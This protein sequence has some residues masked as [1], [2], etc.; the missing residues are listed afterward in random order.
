MNGCPQPG[1]P[2]NPLFGQDGNYTTDPKDPDDP[3]KLLPRYQVSGDGTIAD[4]ITGLLWEVRTDD[5]KDWN[6]AGDLI[7]T[8]NV[9]SCSGEYCGWRLPTRKELLFIVDFGKVSPP[10]IDARFTSTASAGYWTSNDFASDPGDAWI[11]RFD[12]G[13]A[14]SAHK[15]EKHH[16]LA[17]RSA[18]PPAADCNNLVDSQDGTVTDRC[19]GLMWQQPIAE[20]R[21]IWRDALSYADG[22]ELAACTDW[23]VP[24][25]KELESIVALDRHDPAMDTGGFP[26]ARSHSIW[27]STTDAGNPGH[28]WRMSFG[29]GYPYSGDKLNVFSVRAVRTLAPL[30]VSALDP[31]AGPAGGGTVVTL[32]GT[33][34]GSRQGTGSVSLGSS[35]G[36]SSETQATVASWAECQIVCTVPAHD[37]GAVSVTV[38]NDDGASF[39]TKPETPAFTYT[40]DDAPE[41]PS[42][43]GT[44]RP[45]PPA[46]PVLEMA[47]SGRQITLS[48]APVDNATGYNLILAI[49]P[50]PRRVFPV[51]L[52]N[53]NEVSFTLPKGLAVSFLLQ[54]ANPS[55]SSAVSN[56]VT[57]P[58]R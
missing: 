2:R 5:E 13:E 33:G 11:V 47:A 56:P 1:Q 14:V 25:I 46:A 20:A 19:T 4:E 48:W 52:G 35:Q 36:E 29:D 9:E 10:T 26:C 49:Y 28:A 31:T 18:Q 41:A 58:L 7:A 21:R 38:T 32:T 54:A 8:L 3:K 43:P 30:H 39:T 53:I 17:V 45:G 22:L 24:T 40:A 50:R 12:T 34:F 37:P 57:V 42:S 15:S 23:R 16:V 55:G 44:A 6:E 51:R 27:S